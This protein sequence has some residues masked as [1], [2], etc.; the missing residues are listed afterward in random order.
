MQ[1]NNDNIQINDQI[2]WRKAGL[3]V[4]FVLPG[5][6]PGKPSPHALGI[7]SRILGMSVQDTRTAL[8][9]FRREIEAPNR[10]APRLDS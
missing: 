5:E 1:T 3:A 8:S 10:P 7:A 6:M 2:G 9:V 4:S